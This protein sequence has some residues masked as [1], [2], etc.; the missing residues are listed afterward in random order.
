MLRAVLN[1]VRDLQNWRF[2]IPEERGTGFEDLEVEQAGTRPCSAR[3]GTR[4]TSPSYTLNLTPMG[5][6]PRKYEYEGSV[7]LYDFLT[8]P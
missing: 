7:P 3:L 5:A 2:Q 6:S 1:H 4:T 8:S